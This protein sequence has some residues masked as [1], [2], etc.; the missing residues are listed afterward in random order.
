[1]LCVQSLV[2][3]EVGGAVSSCVTGLPCCPGTNPRAL[4]RYST[5]HFAC[6][7]CSILAPFEHRQPHPQ[8]ERRCISAG[9][10]R[11]SVR[12]D[13]ST[14][15]VRGLRARPFTYSNPQ[16]NQPHAR[17]QAER[18]D[19]RPRKGTS[20]WR[21]ALKF[22]FLRRKQHSPWNGAHGR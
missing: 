15:R 22:F 13:S 9:T 10:S 11:I 21:E 7:R 14:T 1:M 16:R 12:S 2:R 6:L 8:T 4:G 19:A 17:A 5:L 3:L 20:A 18:T